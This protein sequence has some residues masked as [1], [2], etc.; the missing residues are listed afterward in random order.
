MVKPIFLEDGYYQGQELDTYIRGL[1]Y[2]RWQQGQALAKIVQECKDALPASTP[3]HRVLKP[4]PPTQSPSPASSCSTI[5]FSYESS[6]EMLMNRIKSSL[7]MEGL[8]VLY[9]NQTPNQR[10]WWCETAMG[11]DV[12]IPILSQTYIESQTCG[13]ELSWARNKGLA[14]LPILAENYHAC[15]PDLEMIL[16]RCGHIP[17]H[18]SFEDNFESNMMKL[19]SWIDSMKR[20]LPESNVECNPPTQAAR[21]ESR[22]SIPSSTE[23]WAL[24][25]GSSRAKTKNTM[26][27]PRRQ[28]P[29]PAEVKGH[30]VC[31]FCRTS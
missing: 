10:R 13:D 8:R 20:L 12:V 6:D 29:M 25:N 18:G 1:Q 22:E 5:L 11:C 30:S 16:M 7:E 27:C 28:G 21:D 17:M 14:L 31:H 2:V 3:M 26:A 24:K 9:T 15:P 4:P 19:Q 23:A